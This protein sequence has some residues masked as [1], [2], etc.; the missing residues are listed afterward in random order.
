MLDRLRQPAPLPQSDDSLTAELS[1][2]SDAADRDAIAR[3]RSGDVRAL[4]DLYHRHASDLLRLATRLL[5]SHED[6]EDV[7]HDVFVAIVGAVSGL[8]DETNARAWLRTLTINRC[9]DRHRSAARR[10]ALAI[11]VDAPS[12]HGAESE[13]AVVS[14]RIEQAV[15]ALPQTLRTVFV[16]RAAEGHSHSEIARLLGIR[17][18]TSEVRYH[19]AVRALRAALGDLK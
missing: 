13:D 4:D 16:L 18:G 10:N 1:S 19:R 12:V 15:A 5:A 14:E 11:H 6:G 2:D 17:A 7:V 8:R 3:L 9:I